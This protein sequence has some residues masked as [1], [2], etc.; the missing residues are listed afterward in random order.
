MFEGLFD[1]QGLVLYEFIPEGYIVNK[2]K[3]IH[4]NLPSPLG[5]SEE[6]T[7]LKMGIKELVPSAGQCTCTSQASGK[8]LCCQ[9]QCDS[10]GAFSIFSGLVAANF[11][12]FL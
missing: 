8:K 3:N 2:R 10:F 11:F 7:S 5:C 9:A 4:Q 1:A 6:E 12:L